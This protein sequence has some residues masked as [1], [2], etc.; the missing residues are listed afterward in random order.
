MTK[1]KEHTP[2][3]VINQDFNRK[4]FKPYN[5]MPYLMERYKAT[6]PKDRPKTFEEFKEF[7]DKECL[8]MYWSRCQYEIVLCPLIGDREEEATKIDIYWQ[9]KMNFDT[10]VRILMDN[11]GVK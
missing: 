8:Y 9:I 6:K 3:Y 11:V 2:F 5:I 7:V 4:E 10:V 1:K